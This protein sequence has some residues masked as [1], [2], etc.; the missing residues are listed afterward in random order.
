MIST[1]SVFHNTVV[2]SL[3]NVQALYINDQKI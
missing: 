2:M 1:L 3:H